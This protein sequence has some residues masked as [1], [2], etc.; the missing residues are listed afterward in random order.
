[1]KKALILM[2]LL[3]M[4]VAFA[5]IEKGDRITVYDEGDA[6]IG[7]H[8]YMDVSINN[9]NDVFVCATKEK[10]HI[11]GGANLKDSNKWGAAVA[12]MKNILANSDFTQFDHY[13]CLRARV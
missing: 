7:R 6:P 3:L 5:N 8:A 1:M 9:I 2:A 13:G 11:S 12:M 4:P 10:T